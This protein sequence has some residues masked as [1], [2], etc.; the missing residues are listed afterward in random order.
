MARVNRWLIGGAIL[1]GGL[2]SGLTAHSFHARATPRSSAGAA[3]TPTGA[4]ATS[5]DHA[6]GGG[7][8]LAPPSGAPTSAPAP[9]PVAPV[10]SGGS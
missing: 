5:A 6:A 10:V 3:S 7:A 8:G 4:Q 1:L 9:A 2:L